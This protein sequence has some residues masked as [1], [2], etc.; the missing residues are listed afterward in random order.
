M[1]CEHA[2]LSVPR[3]IRIGDIWGF[4][5]RWTATLFTTLAATAFASAAFSAA[6]FTSS[7]LASSASRTRAM[8]ARATGPAGMTATVVG[9]VA[10]SSMGMVRNRRRLSFS[11]SVSD[12]DRGGME[13]GRD[14]LD[15]EAVASGRI[16]LDV[17]AR[18]ERT[19]HGRPGGGVRS[20]A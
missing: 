17:G 12:I 15:L 2:A 7:A 9:I 8:S 6:A 20:F 16:G 13:R 18:R 10:A 3:R 14:C 4:V 19:G 11:S 5:W 1:L